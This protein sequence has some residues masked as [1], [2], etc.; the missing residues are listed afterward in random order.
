MRIPGRGIIKNLKPTPSTLAQTD[1][2]LIPAVSVDVPTGRPSL[3][4]GTVV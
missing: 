2:D 1:N 4:V 3:A